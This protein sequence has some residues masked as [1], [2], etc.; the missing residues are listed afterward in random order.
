[1]VQGLSLSLIY[2]RRSTAWPDRIGS[3]WVPHLR[4]RNEDG[5]RIQSDEATKYNSTRVV[6]TEAQLTL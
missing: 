6:V 4:L 1:M 2:M 3:F 5:G